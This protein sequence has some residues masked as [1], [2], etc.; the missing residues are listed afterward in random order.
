MGRRKG[1]PRLWPESRP[2]QP[3]PRR[4]RPQRSIRTTPACRPARKGV[5]TARSPLP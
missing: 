5:G 1:G 2:P 3:H 4:G